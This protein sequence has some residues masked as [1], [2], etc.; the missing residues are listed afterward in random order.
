LQRS[1]I[2]IF[3]VKE[4]K[5]DQEKDRNQV[6]VHWQ[7]EVQALQKMNELDKNHIVRFITAF[8]CGRPADLHHYLMFEWADGGNLI[9]LWEAIPHPVRTS[10]F[11]QA[12]ASELLGLA[13][14]L[15]AAHYMV[16]NSSYRHGD[17]KPANIL[18]FRGGGGAI[19][20]LK[21]GDWGEA[22]IHFINTEARRH[23][24]S[25]K[26]ATR[27]YE[28]PE[29]GTGLTLG[30]SLEVDANAKKASDRRSRLYDIW[31][32]GCI[33]L[34]VVV[35]LLYGYEGLEK[36]NGEIKDDTGHVS[37][38]Y[39][40]RKDPRGQKYAEV[41]EVVGAWMEHMAEHA[42]CQVGISA[43]GDLLEIIRIGLLVVKLPD[44]G[45]TQDFSAVQETPSAKEVIPLQNGHRIVITQEDH[46]AE[47]VLPNGSFSFAVTPAD[48]TDP[49]PQPQPVPPNKFI[50]KGKERIRA[51]DL[52][53]RLEHI[54]QSSD[55][56]YWQAD[57]QTETSATQTQSAPYPSLTIRTRENE[58]AT[59]QVRGPA[60]PNYEHP[61]LD[62]D[63]WRY[64][65]DNSFA[66]A[67][68]KH[69]DGNKKLLMPGP[70]PVA[71]LCPHC[72]GLRDF[73]WQP[74][75]HFSM[76][77]SDLE[78]RAKLDKCSLCRLLWKACNSVQE[79]ETPAEVLNFR[80]IDAGLCI[81][82]SRLPALSTFRGPCKSDSFLTTRLCEIGRLTIRPRCRKPVNN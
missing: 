37:P 19:G 38:F 4:I 2:T 63:D 17:L 12:V 3:A 29:S 44:K 70:V 32:I 25:A 81:N 54:T 49:I 53:R 69:L 41:H 78:N 51:T 33:F 77:R 27:R 64:K 20:T 56:S 18:W 23:N 26:Y 47:D 36:F 9:N 80:R 55:D 14:V 35:W 68:F 1:D 46:D 31:G 8:R 82:D 24:T 21:I 59:L 30:S 71:E 50:T 10:S 61:T 7:S 39:Q 67:L 57:G 52:K 48:L 72:E 76:E 34:E 16:H 66:T 22:K 73:V 42:S 74:T 40:V 65:L 13:S 28:A 62:P 75:A 58:S 45:G 11:M 60:Q 79:T 5:V 6:A 15:A 43:L